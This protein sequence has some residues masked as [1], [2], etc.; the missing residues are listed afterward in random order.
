MLREDPAN[1]RRQDPLATNTFLSS[2]LNIILLTSTLCVTSGGPP[3]AAVL[4]R[5]PSLVR[6]LD[7]VVRWDEIN[8]TIKFTVNDVS[9]FE[10]EGKNLQEDLLIIK[11]N[12]NNPA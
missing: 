10:E 4:Q 2:T 5:R 6:S 9:Y 3:A 11:R 12:H 7:G 8:H 1:T